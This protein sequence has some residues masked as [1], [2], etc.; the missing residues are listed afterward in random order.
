M[1]SVAVLGI[2]V[3]DVDRTV[4]WLLMVPAAAMASVPR[5]RCCGATTW[6]AG[7]RGGGARGQRLHLAQRSGWLVREEAQAPQPLPQMGRP[8]GDGSPRTERSLL[9]LCL[10]WEERVHTE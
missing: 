3:D 5:P 6:A 9:R 8:E 4:A 10:Q 7:L 1:A 2:D